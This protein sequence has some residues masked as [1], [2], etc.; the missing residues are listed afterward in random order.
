M[1]EMDR[2]AVSSLAALF[3]LG[4]R[5]GFLLFRRTSTVKIHAVG[6]PNT[7]RGESAGAFQ[8]NRKDCESAIDAFLHAK[9]GE[10]VSS[11][12]VKKF[13]CPRSASEC[14]KHLPLLPA[15]CS[16]FFC[17]LSLL[18]TRCSLR[19][20]VLGTSCEQQS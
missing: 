4:F 9:A 19:C 7:K 18:R 20:P 6:L 5:V 11:V 17:K 12:N 8:V 1:L 13:V 10:S 14:T 15:P 16:L 3:W 2:T